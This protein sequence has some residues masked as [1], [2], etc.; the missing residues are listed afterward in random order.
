MQCRPP[1]CPRINNSWGGMRSLSDWATSPRVVVNILLLLAIKG[2]TKYGLAA[3]FPSFSLPH[4]QQ[5]I[6]PTKNLA[7]MRGE[8]RIAENFRHTMAQRGPKLEFLDQKYLFFLRNFS[9]AELWGTYD[10]DCRQAP[11]PW[12]ERSKVINHSMMQLQMPNSSLFALLQPCNSQA[13]NLN[14]YR[15]LG[16]QIQLKIQ[17]QIQSHKYKTYFLTAPCLHFCNIAILRQRI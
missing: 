1:V 17:I 8:G 9:S 15:G 16:I 2:A 14:F 6:L 4:Y 11:W 10:H 5:I 13:K 3:F 7:K 12:L